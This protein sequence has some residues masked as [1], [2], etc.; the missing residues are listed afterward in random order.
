M[1]L[2]QVVVTKCHGKRR[3]GA[4]SQWKSAGD[5]SW[6]MYRQPFRHKSRDLHFWSCQ[7]KV[8]TAG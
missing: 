1:S 2:C 5:A 8:M 6:L 7:P 3:R 4:R